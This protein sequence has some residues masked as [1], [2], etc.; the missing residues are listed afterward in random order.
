VG[1]CL[2]AKPLLSN[3]SFIFAYHAVIAQQWVYMLQY[4]LVSKGVTVWKLP[5]VSLIM[6]AKKPLEHSVVFSVLVQLDF[7]QFS[8][9]NRCL[10]NCLG[11]SRFMKQECQHLSLLFSS[12]QGKSE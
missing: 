6:A 7:T 9:F 1:T 12:K 3:G 4:I 5:L 10:P 2:F 11:S 8:D